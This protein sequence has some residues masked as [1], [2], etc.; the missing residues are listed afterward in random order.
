MKRIL[1]I[2]AVHALVTATGSA[3]EVQTLMAAISQNTK[4]AQVSQ[5]KIDKVVDETRKIVE[6]YNAVNK[7]IDGLEVYNT[8]LERQIADQRAEMAT[9]TES[10]DE[11]TVIERQILPLMMRMIDGLDKFVQLDVPFLEE[12]RHKRV[13]FLRTMIERAD[14]GVSEK[15]RRVLEAYQI[16]NDY[17]RTIEAYRGSLEVGGLNAEVD[18]LRIGRVALYYQTIDGVK[19]GVWDQKAREWAELP[20]TYRN[21]IKQG[22]RIAQKQVAPNLLL[23]PVSAPEVVQ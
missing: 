11:V 9:L 3:Q 6:E 16:E 18:F 10:I 13:N 15:L 21:Q 20:T 1:A 2:L 4:A 14:V 8:L 22:L 19:S 5:K 17:G 23:L 12:E 7:E